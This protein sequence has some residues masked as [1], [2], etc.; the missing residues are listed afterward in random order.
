[1]P[2]F[3]SNIVRNNHVCEISVDTRFEFENESECGD[4]VNDR[5]TSDGEGRVTSEGQCRT[6]A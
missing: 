2:E 3:E 5:I 6:I 1:M 4:G